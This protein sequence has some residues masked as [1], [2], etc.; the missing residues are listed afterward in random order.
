[1]SLGV[2]EE[3]VDLALVHADHSSCMPIVTRLD[4]VHAVDVAG[5]DE[6]LKLLNL[7]SQLLDGDLNQK[8]S[9]RRLIKIYLPT[10]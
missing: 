4:L 7:L 9:F 3:I 5:L 6:V 1:M 10:S 8:K 2:V